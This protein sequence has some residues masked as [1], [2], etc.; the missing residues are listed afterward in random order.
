MAAETA[1]AVIVSA[2]DF[3]E[4]AAGALR[5]GV[6]MAR[7]C[8]A[9]V[10]AVH[11]VEPLLDEAARI[12]G[13]ES[14]R[15]D[16]AAALEKWVAEEVPST[17]AGHVASEVVVGDPPVEILRVAQRD[18]AMLIVM[19]TH[20]MTG[21]R[22]LV[23]GSVTRHVLHDADRPILVIP[24]SAPPADRAWLFPAPPRATDGLL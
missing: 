9:R 11:V 21:Y 20:G 8:R 5:Y 15:A 17:A 2:T 22:R 16:T 19:G 12:K 23:F 18:N 10:L 24:P 3:S 7:R 1:P 13:F 6:V 14:F 4:N